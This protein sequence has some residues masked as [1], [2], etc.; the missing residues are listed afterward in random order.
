VTVLGETLHPDGRR[1]VLDELGWAHIVDEHS[2]MVAFQA[3]L[4]ATLKSPDHRTPDPRPGRERYW[5][6]GFGP[7]Q[8]LFVVVDFDA[9][10]ARVVTAYGNREDPPGW[11]P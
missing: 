9:D 5:R 4:L 6:T 10:P 3:D 2:E 1:V 11:T 8:W 7:S